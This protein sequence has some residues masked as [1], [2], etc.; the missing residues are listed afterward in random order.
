M[1]FEQWLAT[2][3]MT[4]G[5]AIAAPVPAPPEGFTGAQYIDSTG[6]VFARDAGGWVARLD[7][8]G[9]PLCGFP[10]SIG[11]R[12]TAVAEPP[13]PD[14]ETLLI[15]Q[16]TQQLRP[17]EWAADPGQPEQRKPAE[18]ARQPDPIQTVL[19]D[20]L[21]VAPALR[22]VTGLEVSDDLC[23]RLGYAPDAST[24]AAAG[25]ALGLCPGMRAE[26]AKQPVPAT[27]TAPAT[28]PVA[29]PASSVVARRAKPQPKPE[30]T[31]EMIPASAR[32]IQVGAFQDGDNALIV[33]RALSARGYPVAQTRITEK[34]K[35]MRV[36]MAGPF[37]DRQK[38]VE[39]LV[40]LRQTG[41]AGAMP[42]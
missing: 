9:Q 20:A 33:L 15:E 21:Q 28:K 30:A 5:A 22:Q 26:G 12:R 11:V 14:A 1:R 37:P 39:A 19:T 8:A 17:G 7:G 38:L 18:P 31:V 13:A 23:A 32:Y 42:R 27:R 24:P 10:P 29:K 3:M 34:A 41:Y 35:G 4:G 25:A 40:E 36:V 16:L 2:L 6:C